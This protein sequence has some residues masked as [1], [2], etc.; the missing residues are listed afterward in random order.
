MGGLISF[1]DGQKVNALLLNRILLAVILIA[2]GYGKLFEKG[3]AEVSSGWAQ[4]GMIAGGLLGYIVPILEFFGGIAIL[5]GVAT[6]LLS[7]WVIVQFALIVV[8]VKPVVFGSSVGE[9]FVDIAI[10]G[11]ALI[12]AAYGAGAPALG[13]MLF[14]GKRWAE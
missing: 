6:R 5:L 13:S 2:A 4:S 1:L 14:K 12:L 10:V 7:V 9:S 3:L 8:Y 11:Q